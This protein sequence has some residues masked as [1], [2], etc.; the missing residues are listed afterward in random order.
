MTEG[1]TDLPEKQLDPV[2]SVVPE[3]LRKNLVTCEPLSPS[4][5]A[6]AENG[7][8][9]RARCKGSRTPMENHR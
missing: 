1:R 8:I 3:Y 5:S 6:H 4:R 2:G 9:Q 7:R